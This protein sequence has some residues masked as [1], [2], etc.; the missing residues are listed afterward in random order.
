MRCQRLEDWKPFVIVNGV[1]LCG[2]CEKDG[3]TPPCG[4]YKHAFFGDLCTNCGYRI[5]SVA[6][7]IAIVEAPKT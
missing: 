7:S 3:L 5:K 6:I 2:C 1:K 4:E